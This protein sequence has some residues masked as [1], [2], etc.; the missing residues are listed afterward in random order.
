MWGYGSGR[1]RSGNSGTTSDFCQIDVRRW[2]R[3]GL[4][5]AGQC[6]ARQWTQNSEVVAAITVRT[7]TNQVVL[8]Y[9]SNNDSC[10][11]L[12]YAV[13]LEWTPC[14]YGG[15]RAWFLC[16]AGGCGRR[17][18]I[19]YL[20]C[21][22]F[23]CRHCY[24]LKYRSQREAPYLTAI[25]RAQAIRIKLGGSADLNMPF[26]WKPEGMRWST[27]QRLCRQSEEAEARSW[28]KWLP[29]QPSGPLGSRTTRRQ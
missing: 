5:Q 10:S 20:G 21:A 1:H 6:F 7:E 27:Y 23:A 14:H 13:Q 11:D 29:R 12:E 24:Q 22:V 18:A 16:P 17:V 28:P 8:S 2:Q 25:H 19:L 3:D 9:P 4:L 15:L 26:P